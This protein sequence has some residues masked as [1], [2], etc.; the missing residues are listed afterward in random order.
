MI[1]KSMGYD[2]SFSLEGDGN[3]LKK[4]I[5][6]IPESLSFINI[7]VSKEQNFE[8]PRVSIDPEIIS[9]RFSKLCLEK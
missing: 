7:K 1:A 5:N 6:D 8:V 3:E 2:N 4:L 9:S